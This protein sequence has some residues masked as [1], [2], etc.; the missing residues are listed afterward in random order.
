MFAERYRLQKN[1]L[2][3]RCHVRTF[4]GHTQGKLEHNVT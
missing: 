2:K 3:S 4:E 1:W